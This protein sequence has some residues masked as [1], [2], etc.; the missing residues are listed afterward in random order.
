MVTWA[1][2]CAIQKAAKDSRQAVAAAVRGSSRRRAR[3][4]EVTVTRGDATGQSPTDRKRFG[5]PP[6]G[7]CNVLRVA[8]REARKGNPAGRKLRRAAH[9]KGL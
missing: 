5:E 8:A 7:P 4:V 6:G 1:A 2:R 3:R 9:R